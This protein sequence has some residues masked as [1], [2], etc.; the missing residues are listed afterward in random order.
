MKAKKTNVEIQRGF[1]YNII[2]TDLVFAKFDD[3]FRYELGAR[4]F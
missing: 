4:F 3:R 1:K 2:W